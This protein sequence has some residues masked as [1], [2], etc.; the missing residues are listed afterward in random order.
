MC[1]R[2]R[3]VGSPICKA[4]CALQALRPNTPES[5]KQFQTLLRQSIAHLNFCMKLYKRRAELGRKFLH[6]HPWSASSWSR[7]SVREVLDLPGVRLVRGDQCRFGACSVDKDGPGLIRKATDWMSNDDDILAAV[8]LPC[9]NRGRPAD[10]PHHRH[11][12]LIQ[13]RPQ[14]A[15]RYPEKLVLAILKG[16]RKSMLNAGQLNSV[17]FAPPAKHRHLDEPE[18]MEAL[19]RGDYGEVR[20]LEHV[21]NNLDVEKTPFHD[22]VAGLPLPEG[23][24]RAA[25]TEELE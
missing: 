9:L 1:I 4:F 12:H 18:P 10:S 19:D 13:G 5:W 20:P 22:E 6:E 8:A 15:E 14:A 24:V 3:L 16:L 21:V 11:V 17:E 7:P 23:L 25:R 2:D